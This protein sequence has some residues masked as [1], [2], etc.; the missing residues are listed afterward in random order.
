M[1]QMA[2]FTMTF[3]ENITCRKKAAERYKRFRNH[4]ED[5][6][7]DKVLVKV[8][9]P[10]QR[11]SLH[12]HCM[13]YVGEDIRT[14]FDFEAYKHAKE[15]NERIWRDHG[16]F[17]SCPGSLRR[18]HSNSTQ[19]YA[20]SAS[21]KLRSMWFQLRKAAKKSGFGRC[22]LVPIQHGK[23]VSQYVGKYLAKGL[24]HTPA[25]MKGMRKINYC[26]GVYRKVS[27]TFAWA[28]GKTREWRGNLARWAKFRRVKVND[29]EELQRRYG[30]G[31]AKKIFDEVTHIGQRERYLEAFATPSGLDIHEMRKDYDE[32]AGWSRWDEI[33][34]CFDGL[35]R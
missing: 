20:R 21:A 8:A 4:F 27:G 25:G 1:D 9:E 3:K 7:I 17:K 29:Y 11:G 14:G 18:I 13:V 30:K 15:M 10:Q 34:R 35:Y 5:I 28:Y 22:E 32:A 12:Y 2:F 26:R 16:G 6:G 23:A 31:W 19:Q 24:G 33:P